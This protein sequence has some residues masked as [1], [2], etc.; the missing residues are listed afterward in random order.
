MESHDRP[1]TEGARKKIKRE[2]WAA[3]FYFQIISFRR[4][5][6][7]YAHSLPHLS[8]SPV[9][10]PYSSLL[11]LT[12]P[13]SVKQT[14]FL[15][16]FKS[17]PWSSMPFLHNVFLTRPVIQPSSFRRH[18]RVDIARGRQNDKGNLHQLHEKPNN[19]SN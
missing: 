6:S 10:H 17:L 5:L 1:P 12:F 3:S 19:Y 8:T 4:L 14:A 18:L 15:H 9:P 7:L 11:Q 16:F 13:T 2:K